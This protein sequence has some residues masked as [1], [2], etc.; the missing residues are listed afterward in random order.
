MPPRRG[1]DAG[2]SCG[3]R[4]ARR[5]GRARSRTALPRRLTERRRRSAEEGV[6]AAAFDAAL[7]EFKTMTTQKRSR[8]RSA[9]LEQLEPWTSFHMMML[10]HPPHSAHP[11]SLI[12]VLPEPLIWEFWKTLL[13]E[14][15]L[16]LPPLAA[17]V[18][19]VPMAPLFLR[20]P[21]VHA[22]SKRCGTYRCH[23]MARRGK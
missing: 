5:R 8:P 23:Q 1:R 3:G 12:A 21:V 9:P 20:A 2:R 14:T 7:Q 11:A 16:T 10:W 18:C 22:L 6:L 4:G 17:T 15:L 19:R 13:F